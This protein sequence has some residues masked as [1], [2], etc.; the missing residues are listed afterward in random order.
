MRYAIV[1]MMLV[2]AIALL[3]W[4]GRFERAYDAAARG[5]L[6]TGTV[7]LTRSIRQALRDQDYDR[8]N[9]PYYR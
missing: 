8:G 4:E 1:I 3:G 2:S 9:R 7:E 6:R 5:E